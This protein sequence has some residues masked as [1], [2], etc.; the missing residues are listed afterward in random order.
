LRHGSTYLSGIPT[1]ARRCFGELW[2]DADRDWLDC[3]LAAHA[4][5]SPQ[6]YH[7]YKLLLVTHPRFPTPI[8][9]GSVTAPSWLRFFTIE[10]SELVTSEVSIVVATRVHT[11]IRGVL[12]AVKHGWYPFWLNSNNPLS[13][14][15][16]GE[17]YVYML[18]RD[19]F[20]NRSI[21]F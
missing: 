8:Y 1:T 20:A 9:V 18:H 10:T 11:I 17:I 2:S 13:W 16:E 5:L 3:R 4:S 6:S 12:E 15:F 21:S 7:F 19:S 14:C